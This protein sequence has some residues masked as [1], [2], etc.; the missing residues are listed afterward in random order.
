[1]SPDSHGVQEDVRGLVI[2]PLGRAPEVALRNH[3]QEGL[4]CAQRYLVMEGKNNSPES[5][6]SLLTFDS[7]DSTPVSQTRELQYENGSNRDIS[8][9]RQHLGY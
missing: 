4:P 2:H 9:K 7:S 3:T 6:N 5:T 8:F 1:M